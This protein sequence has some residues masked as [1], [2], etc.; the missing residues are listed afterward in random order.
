MTRK[1]PNLIAVL[2]LTLL[3]VDTGAAAEPKPASGQEWDALMK[4]AEDEGEVAIY[5][6][7]SIGK[8]SVDLGG[9]SKAL[10]QDQA[11]RHLG[12]PGQRS[13]PQT[14]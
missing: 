3:Q 7:D 13:V 2:I 10:S 4:K 1:W 9:I 14:L 11:D 6:T 5:A 8:R 12:G